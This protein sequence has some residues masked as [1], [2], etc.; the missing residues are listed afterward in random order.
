MAVPLVAVSELKKEAKYK[1]KSDKSAAKAE[2][3]RVKR[4]AEL[5]YAQQKTEAKSRKKAEKAK[6]LGVQLQQLQQQQQ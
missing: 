2:K 1:Y 5:L 3:K 4:E 6:L